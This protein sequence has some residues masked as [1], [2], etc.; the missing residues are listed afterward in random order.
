MHNKNVING[1]MLAQMFI[2]GSNNLTNYK[3]E[4]NNLNVFPVPD[5]DTGTNM[6]A[7]TNDAAKLL[8]NSSYSSVSEV[9]NIIARQTLL[10]A[11]GNSGVILSQIF[12]GIATSFNNKDQITIDDWILAFQS[13]KDRAYSSVLKPVEGTILTVIRETSENLA[14]NKYNNIENLFNDVVKFSEISLSE[15]PK[16]LKILRDAGVIDSGGRGLVEI[17]K[18]FQKA[19]TGTIVQINS[20][21]ASSSAFA[22]ISEDPF[23]VFGY[24]TE[25]IMK[26]A[27]VAKFD[28]EKLIN[29]LK[30]HSESLMVIAEDDIL[31]VHCHSQRPGKILETAHGIGDFEHIKIENMSLQSHESQMKNAKIKAQQ[32]KKQK[33]KSAI[34]SCNIGD[35]FIDSMEELGVSEIIIAEQN[36]S[37]SANQIIKA[38]Q[39][40]NAENIFILPNDRDVVMTAN[41]AAQTINDKIVR[42]INT[43]NQ[44]SGLIAA[45][46]FSFD[47]DLEENLELI[48]DGLADLKTAKVTRSS[49]T[50][51]TS[52]IKIKEG[53]FLCY[54]NDKIIN[55]KSTVLKAA[56]Y[57]INEIVDENS[58]IAYIFYGDNVDE[59][60]AQDLEV[61][62]N[63]NHNIDVEIKKG[64]Q[65]IYD[66]VIGIK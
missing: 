58:E 51:K 34:I 38:I 42:V 54:V 49:K 60:D 17:F 41:M 50:I 53:E 1:V 59:V 62:I 45:Q 10:S 24:C 11:R 26:L 35:G 12:K 23:P 29:K 36:I 64:N 40:V 15:T 2:S 6:S 61:Y 19:L 22:S 65:P 32:N 7:T 5:G 20:E 8:E 48:T 57:V 31:K 52:G 43:S 33:T 44:V 28:K 18:G 46:H 4:I 47:N 63:N 3:E 27:H 13:A 25:F 39:N 16:H 14:N 66:F 9:A 37:I 55:T 30:R 56:K 21:Q